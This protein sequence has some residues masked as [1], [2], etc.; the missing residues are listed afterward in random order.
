MT[1]L[2]RPRLYLDEDVFSAVAL[3]LRRRG[4]DV[5]TTIEAANRERSD[6]EQLEFAVAERRCL[7]TFNRGDFANLH[8]QRIAAGQ[9]HFGIVVAPQMRIGQ[10]VRLLARFLS[11]RSAAELRDQLIWISRES[12]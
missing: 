7:F 4:F 11:S 10:A 5:V 1:R 3:G 12:N 2:E 9:H 6:F 8:T